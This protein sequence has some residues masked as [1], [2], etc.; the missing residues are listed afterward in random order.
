MHI[1]RK[2]ME[3]VNQALHWLV[4]DTTPTRPSEQPRLTHYARNRQAGKLIVSGVLS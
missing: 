2:A 3:A 4:I 1:N